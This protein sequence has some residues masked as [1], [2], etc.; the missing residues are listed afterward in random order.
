[1][2]CLELGSMF[3]ASIRCTPGMPKLQEEVL[4]WDI[5]TCWPATGAFLRPRQSNTGE[6]VANR[7]GVLEASE[8]W[9]VSHAAT[10]QFGSRLEVAGWAARCITSIGSCRFKNAMVAWSRSSHRVMTAAQKPSSPQTWEAS[11]PV[12][13]RWLQEAFLVERATW[14]EGGFLGI[15]QQDAK[16]GSFVASQD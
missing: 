1:M 7:E 2:F 11:A 5:C 15:G 3:H 6:V 9:I 12:S 14:V 8:S 4:G 16:L 10:S 13:G